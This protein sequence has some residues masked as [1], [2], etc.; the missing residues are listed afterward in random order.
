MLLL[1]AMIGAQAGSMSNLS[2]TY[3]AT[4]RGWS[5]ADDL[6]RQRTDLVTST[7]C[8][9]G[10]GALLQVSAAATILPLGITPQSAEH[11]VRI[12]GDSMGV[13]GKVIFG[14]GLWGICF[15]SFVGGTM[16][17]SLIVRDICRRFVPGLRVAADAPLL[18]APG[19]R[20]PVYRWS[21]A[22]LGLS[23]LYVVFLAVEPVALTL[24][25][26][27]MVVIVIPVL[28]ASLMKMANDRT[29]MGEHRPGAFSNAVLSLLVVVS[30]Y[31]TVRDS[32]EWWRL[33][34]R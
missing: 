12:F 30:I 32:G 19:S 13:M 26:R 21:A 17:Y 2:Y 7:F 9:F 8:R 15:S 1:A 29:L 10:V 24:V 28:V 23:P 14:V 22:L 34:T 31:L 27:S 16:G 33:L 11:L 25:V 3:F 5:G 20:D 6:R 4:E 18:T